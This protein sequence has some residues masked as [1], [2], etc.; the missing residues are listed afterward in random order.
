MFLGDRMCEVHWA[1]KEKREL[2][3]LRKSED[4][5]SGRVVLETANERVRRLKME[6][7]HLRYSLQAQAIARIV[8]V[9]EDYVARALKQFRKDRL[10]WDVNVA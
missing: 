10:R 4:N 7:L 2:S 1:S 5:G 6:E 3:F 8:H 9:D